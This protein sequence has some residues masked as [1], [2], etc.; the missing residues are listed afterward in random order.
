MSQRIQLSNHFTYGRLIKFVLPSIFMMIFTSIYV[1]VDGFF[2]SNYAGKTPFAAVNLIWPLL[3]IFQTV[4]FVFGTGGSAI[5]AKTLGEGDGQKANEYFSLFTYVSFMLGIVISVFGYIFI[6]P[7]ASLLGGEGEMLS[8]ACLYAR[9]LL[10]AL[11]FSILQVYFQ[12][13]FIT[14]EK[15]VLGFVVTL[16]SGFM[17]IILDAILVPLLPE[18]HK[19]LG[20]AIATVASQLVGGIVPIFYFARK[21]DSVLRFT[22]TKFNLNVLFKA[23]VNGSS[24]FMSNVSM[25][26]VGML[27]NI[28]LFK[29]AGENGIAAYGVMMYVSMIFSAVYIGYT[30]GVAPIISFHYGAKNHDEMKSLLFKSLIIIFAFGVIMTISAE[31]TS[32]PLAK[33][34]VGYDEE[35]MELTVFGFRIFSLAFFFMGFTIFSSGFFTALNNGL[36]SAVISFL[37][38]LVFQIAAVLILPLFLG[39]DGVWVSVVVAEVVAVIISVMFLI[40]KKKTYKY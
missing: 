27:Y 9:V 21:N 10:F 16:S 23:C 39:I 37:R 19:L 38:T 7:I 12:T 1:V 6:R 26:V 34:F 17:N 8:N 35:L 20:A 11:P 31:L 18:E 33:I 3:M 36:I 32:Y 13:F 14:A 24:E 4:G 25:S 40:A 30:I 28:Q 22:K 29:Y 5:V 2:V 15:P